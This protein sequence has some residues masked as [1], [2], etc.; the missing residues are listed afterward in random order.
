MQIHNKKSLLDIRRRLR[1]ESTPAEDF[2][3]QQLRNG[4][5]NKLKFKRQHSIGNYIVDFYCA[6]KRLI[7]E[8]D[9]GI[10]LGS[11]QTEK[12]RLRDENLIEMKFKVLRFTNDEILFNTEYVNNE[13]LKHSSSI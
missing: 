3:W 6:S 10:H 11:D 8:A 13:I 1:K 4:Q 7:I 2:L 9:G 12:D 5:L